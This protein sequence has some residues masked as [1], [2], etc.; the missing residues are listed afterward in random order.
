MIY[1]ITK[2]SAAEMREVVKFDIFD[3]FAYVEN[4]KRGLKK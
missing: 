1:T 3:F 2:G 4:F